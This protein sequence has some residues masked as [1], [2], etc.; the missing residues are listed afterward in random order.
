MATD[1]RTDRMKNFVTEITAEV[2]NI[3]DNHNKL[4]RQQNEDYAKLAVTIAD[5]T[6]IVVTLMKKVDE[7]EKK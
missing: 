3:H 5:L 1:A 4:Q 6:D 2:K 7:L